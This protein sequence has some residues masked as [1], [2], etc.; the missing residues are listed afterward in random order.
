M[1]ARL[2]N[3]A[4][5]RLFLGLHALADPPG[6]S[7]DAAGLQALVERLGFVQV[8]SIAT[9]E[10]AHHLV[11]FAR[12]QGYRRE[13]LARLLE[14]DRRLFENWTHDAA[15]IPTAFFAHW[16][17]RFARERERL[18]E[19]WRGWQGTAWERETEAVLDHV[20]ARGPTVAGDLGE[21]R[22]ASGGWWDWSPRKAALEFLWR[23]GALAVCHRRGLEKVY[24]L[25]ERVLPAVHAAEAPD[26]ATHVAW[27]CAS[28]LDRLGFATPGELAAFW[29]LVS[30][31][32]AK[33]WAR[34]EGDAL[35]P[36]TIEGADGAPRPAL[37]RPGLA[38]R[39]AAAAELPGRVRVLAPFDPVLRDRA[40]AARLFGFDYRIEIY[41]PAAKRRWGYYVFPL[42]EGDRLIGRVDM[43]AERAEGV[44]RV[45]ALWPEAGVRFGK[46]RME[47]LEA[48]LDRLARFAGCERVDFA[49]GWLRG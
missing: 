14:R 21:E 45:A 40:R 38:E 48:E 12:A 18:P 29:G 28:A 20:R 1:T 41:V 11:L 35:E 43:K 31:E 17:P 23:T 36:V 16:K 15:V 6:R 7:L 49:A 32:E 34:A 30:P 27:A 47:R 42:L 37:A 25:T 24:D 9:V 19:R 2:G 44:L 26:R 4:A 10:R 13:D 3:P 33:A 46:G 22:R 39:A 8:D 5:R